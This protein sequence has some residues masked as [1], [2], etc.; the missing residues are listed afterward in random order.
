VDAA[1][2]SKDNF[3]VIYPNNDSGSNIIINEYERLKQNTR[4]KVFPSVRF[5]KFLVLLKKAEYILGNSS[6]GIREAHYYGLP[7]LNVGTRQN[8]RAPTSELIINSQPNIKSLVEAIEISKKTKR[9]PV[10]STFG[11]GN[12][13]KLF[14]EAVQNS[15]FWLIRNQKTFIDIYKNKQQ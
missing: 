8:N 7:S 11:S 3:I 9:I 12:S 4:F 14:F 13:D 1:I 6:A 10:L 2:E 15:S 5:E